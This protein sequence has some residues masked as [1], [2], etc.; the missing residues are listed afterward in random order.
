[1]YKIIGGDGREYGPVTEAE[2]RKWIAEGR[3][4]AQSLAKA[5]S[6]AEF[7]ALATFPEFADAFGTAAHG[8][9]EAASTA[10]A[11]DWSKHDY[12]LD[13][14]GCISRGWTLFM[15]HIGILLGCSVLYLLIIVVGSGGINAVLG[16]IFSL[17]V[18]A[19][20]LY[21]APFIIL[22][23]ILL[24]TI[25]ALFAGPLAGGYY[26]VFIQTLR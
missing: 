19:N 6:D 24:Q 7:R 9:G 26:F 11:I 23:S 25:T 16:G 20:T 14:G 12:E 4:S 15:D 3:L 8:Y 22:Q 13:I 5:E 1:M 21:S 10:P 18:P 2:L 17:V